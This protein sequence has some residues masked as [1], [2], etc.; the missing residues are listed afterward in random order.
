VAVFITACASSPEELVV[1]HTKRGDHYV[2][3]GKFQEAVI[4]YRNAVKAAPDNAAL[5]WK[6]AKAALEA[7]DNKTAY[8]ALQK[9][10][11]L[12]PANYEAKGILGEI[13]IATGETDRASQIAKHSL[14]T[15]RATF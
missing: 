15:R 3:E 13:Y 12:D 7:K 4:E 6:L 1:K 14:K 11:E 8:T 9:T 5:R 2:Q 10:V